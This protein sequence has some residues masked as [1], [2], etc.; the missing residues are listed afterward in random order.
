MRRWGW[1]IVAVM[2]LL[3]GAAGLHWSHGAAPAAVPGVPRALAVPVNSGTA[4]AGRVPGRLTLASYNVAWMLDVF[5]D[6]YTLDESHAPKPR[7]ELEALAAT[8][9]AMDADVV[10]LVEMENQGTLR[11][12]ARELLPDM[13]YRYI[14][15]QPT[16]SDR[17]QNIGILSR[18]PID[19]ITSF[20]EQTLTLPSEDR[21]WHFARDLVRFRLA[22][23]G[24]RMLSLYVVHLKSK[25]ND[26]ADKESARWRLAEAMQVRRI[27]E[28]EHP[29]DGMVQ[30]GTVGEWFILQGDF[31]DTPTSP[32]VQ[33][34]LAGTQP[35][36]LRLS[37]VHAALPPAERVTYLRKPYRSTIDYMLACPALAERLVPGSAKVAGE[38]ANV[39]TGSDHAPVVATFDVRP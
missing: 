23:P 2:A 16:N 36:E 7:V 39:L 12:F 19:S 25:R 30:A 37:D 14:A 10:T 24:D 27:L 9:R 29:R 35:G 21:T 3:A 33:A 18:V 13:G 38:D 15:A 5:D 28:R 32:P 34:L 31:N 26:G 11:A 6:P 8:L 4:S 22:L 1:M 20:R 17:G